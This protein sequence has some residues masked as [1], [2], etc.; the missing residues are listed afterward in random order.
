M[1]QEGGFADEADRLRIYDKMRPALARV[2]RLGDAVSQLTSWIEP[3]DRAAG[4]ADARE[5]LERSAAAAQSALERPVESRIG[6]APGAAR[7]RVL[8]GP[9]LEAAVAAVVVATA[10]EAGDSPVV[11]RASV[12]EGREPAI[13]VVV[14]PQARVDGETPLPLEEGA[15]DFDIAR[16]GMGLSLVLAIAVL[17]AHAA[18][19]WSIGG[20]RS[21][22]VLRLPVAPIKNE[23]QQP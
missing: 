23:E 11:V 4:A 20:A 8:D 13:E 12:R 16:G 1:L 2:A 17:E 7:L 22:A 9:A 6:V 19:V 5:L 15:E 10:R 14:G 21:L 18:R 3:R